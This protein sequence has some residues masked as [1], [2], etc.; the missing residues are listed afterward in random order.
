M[1]SPAHAVTP[2]A[3]TPETSG[4]A[5]RDTG[6]LPL[7]AV[8]ES[9]GRLL[10]MAPQRQYLC[11]AEAV[12]LETVALNRL[13]AQIA[14]ATRA[15]TARRRPASGAPRM[16]NHHDAAIA[17]GVITITSIVFSLSFVAL[18]IT[19]QQLSPRILDYIVQER[20]MALCG[21]AVD[22]AHRDSQR[23]QIIGAPALVHLAFVRLAHDLDRV[24]EGGTQ[25]KR[26]RLLPPS[27]LPPHAGEGDTRLGRE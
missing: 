19:A 12:S 18:S 6:W 10:G 8:V 5:C 1:A 24:A 4:S 15:R 14:A 22:E 16:V 17:T 7:H 27:Y 9:G 3:V 25:Y 23:V 26:R 2:R 21:R 11:S 20:R 13:L